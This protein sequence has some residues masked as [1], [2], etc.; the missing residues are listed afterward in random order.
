M[1]FQI[2][3]ANYTYDSQKR[4]FGSAL[5]ETEEGKSVTCRVAGVP[6]LFLRRASRK[7]RWMKFTQDLIEMAP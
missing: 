6:A 7:A 5:G 3:D 1:I 4:P 2:L